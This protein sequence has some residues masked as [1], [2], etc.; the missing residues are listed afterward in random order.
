M[1]LGEIWRFHTENEDPLICKIL[2][3]IFSLICKT[4]HKIVSFVYMEISLQGRGVFFQKMGDTI[5]SQAIFVCM[6]NEA[7][8]G[9]V[10]NVR[11]AWPFLSHLLQFDNRCT[12]RDGQSLVFYYLHVGQFWVSMLIT[13]YCEKKLLWS[14]IKDAL[15]SDY[16]G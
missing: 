8:E 13:I 4:L 1:T 2:Y 11:L 14:H 3:K 9:R 16:N 7:M 6:P 15:I 10:C 5:C 12:I